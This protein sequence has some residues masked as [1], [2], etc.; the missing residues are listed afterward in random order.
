MSDR[1]RISTLYFNNTY[2][3][4][5]AHTHTHTHYLL[6]TKSAHL[7][8]CTILNNPRKCYHIHEHMH[9]MHEHAHAYQTASLHTS[10]LALVCCN[11]KQHRRARV[12]KYSKW[13]ITG[14]HTHHSIHDTSELKVSQVLKGKSRSLSTFKRTFPRCVDEN[15]E[16]RFLEQAKNCKPALKESLQTWRHD[17]RKNEKKMAHTLLLKQHDL[18]IFTAVPA[19]MDHHQG[20]LDEGPESH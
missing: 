4:R 13:C 12:Y 18:L 17:F 19:P 11:Q 16:L 5:R 1:A 2:T 8:A 14:K 3:H 7:P 6:W 15:T 9:I 10:T 20:T